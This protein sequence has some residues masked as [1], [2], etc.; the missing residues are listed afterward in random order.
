M[1]ISLI[2]PA[3]DGY[4]PVQTFIER[5]SRQNRRS[6]MELLVLCRTRQEFDGHE[7]GIDKLI[8]C[9][10]EKL[11]QA[12]WRALQEADGEYVLFAED[13]CIPE[14]GWAE[15][16]LRRSAEDW[17]CI[18]FAMLP[19]NESSLAARATFLLGYGQ[20]LGASSGPCRHVAGNHSLYL[21]QDL[22]DLGDSQMLIPAL[23]QSA[24]LRRRPCFLESE[25]ALRHWDSPGLGQAVN[26][27]F[28]IGCGFG[29]QRSR[30][31]PLWKRVTFVLAFPLIVLAH[32][33]RSLRE[34]RRLRQSQL[35]MLTCLPLAL[36]WACGE[37]L[38][39]RL[40]LD[41]CADLVHSAER[42]HWKAIR[43]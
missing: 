23:A 41:R 16:A 13:H 5:F 28:S 27:V 7:G 35:V 17:P 40:N 1:K 25:G 33:R 42:D 31:W 3:L 22:L 10:S 39:L 36:A 18:G 14:P 15:A 32:W 30:A 37:I 8:E 34:G 26:T 38:G 2:L 20:W 4:A 6:Q 43:P 21:R 19:G 24:L 29:H 12:R 9:G 11:H